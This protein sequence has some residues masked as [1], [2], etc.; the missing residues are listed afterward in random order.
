MDSNSKFDLR[1][2]T[3]HDVDKSVRFQCL[4]GKTEATLWVLIEPDP[5]GDEKGTHAHFHTVIRCPQIE[6][7]D[8]PEPDRCQISGKT[9]PFIAP[10]GSPERNLELRKFNYAN[11]IIQMMAFV[12]FYGTQLVSIMLSSKGV[13]YEQDNWGLWE[14]DRIMIMCG[15]I[16]K[17][18]FKKIDELR[19]L[20]NKLAHKP[21]QYLKFTEKQLF[22][23]S[24]NASE[25]SNT[26]R[27]IVSEFNKANL[28]S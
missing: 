22:Q 25:I 14:L 2:A 15:L 10:L 21:M 13:A 23:L 28:P 26:V 6:I 18:T 12:E 9:C 20:R 17:E 3:K 8:I 24:M 16:D 5:H 4:V 27:K 7:V 19:K 1:K 11:M